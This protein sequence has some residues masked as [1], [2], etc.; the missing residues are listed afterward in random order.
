M[1]AFTS[2]SLL[3]GNKQSQHMLLKPV[4]PPLLAYISL[5]S[6]A[7]QSMHVVLHAW[8]TAK[9]NTA[10]T[11]AILI[12]VCTCNEG[13]SGGQHN[14]APALVPVAFMILPR[15]VT[16]FISPSCTPLLLPFQQGH[17]SLPPSCPQHSNGFAP[18]TVNL[19]STCLHMA[20]RGPLLSF[21]TESTG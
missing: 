16:P 11:R 19:K 12:P 9:A 20:R 1:P 17:T 2:K 7:P 8:S 10:E 13:T 6:Q 15:K 18:V 14:K 3:E 4:L 5:P 21:S